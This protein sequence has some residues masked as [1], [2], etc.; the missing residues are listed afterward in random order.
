MASK[1]LLVVV[2]PLTDDQLA[3]NRASHLAADIDAGVLLFCC[4]YLEDSEMKQYTSRRDAKQSH[5]ASTREWLNELAAPLQNQ[6]LNVSTEVVWNKK[7]EVMVAQAAARH[8]A[9]LI[10]KS[11]FLHG[12]LERKFSRTSDIYLMRSASCPVLL[13]KSDDAWQNNIV[14]AAVSLEASD[15]STHDLLNN[16]IITISQ[17][18]ARAT[19]AELH[20]VSAL[21]KQP[22]LAEVLGILDDEDGTPDEIAAQRFGVPSARMHIKSGSARD[23]IVET[24]QLLHADVVVLGTVGR[25]GIAATLLGNTAEKVLDALETDVMTVS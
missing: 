25:T 23:V 4:T 22:D 5:L 17:R 24:A 19:K 7:W 16:Q 1:Q 2:D 12:V 3:L 8:G 6:G 20:L 11:S 9:H 14:L 18:L 15:N 10:V 21:E 13:V